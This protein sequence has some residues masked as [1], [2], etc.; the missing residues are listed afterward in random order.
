MVRNLKCWRSYELWPV[1]HVLILMIYYYN[2]Q[3]AFLQAYENSDSGSVTTI[4]LRLVCLHC[5]AIYEFCLAFCLAY[6]YRLIHT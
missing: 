6:A 1:G 3:H 5:L 4:L 2:I